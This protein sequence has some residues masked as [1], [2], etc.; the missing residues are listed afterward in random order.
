MQEELLWQGHMFALPQSNGNHMCVGLTCTSMLHFPAVCRHHPMHFSGYCVHMRVYNH[1]CTHSLLGN[2]THKFIHTQ[3]SDPGSKELADCRQ[4]YAYVEMTLGF[5][6]VSSKDIED[7]SLL[8][9]CTH[10][11]K[12]LL[13]KI[14]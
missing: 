7:V 11:Y 2:L 3:T 9:V 1:S 13:Q 4:F 14:I 8:R 10:V 12:D 6:G 5:D